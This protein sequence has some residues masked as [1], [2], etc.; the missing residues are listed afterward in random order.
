MKNPALAHFDEPGPKTRR[1][2]TWLTIAGAFAL[3]GIIYYVLHRFS[4]T[5]QLDPSKWEPFLY[6]DI[7]RELLLGLWSTLK[8]ALISSVLTLLI[9]FSFGII[10]LSNSPWIRLPITYLIELIRGVPVLLMIFIMFYLGSG[11]LSP[12]WSVVLGVSIFNGSVVA[13]IVRAGI[14]SLPKG[15]TEAGSAIGLRNF[16]VMRY[17]RLPQAIRAMMPALVGQMVVMLKDSS[18][19]YLVTYTDLLYVTNNLGRDFNNLL[20]TFLVGAAVYVLLNICLGGVAKVLELRMSGGFGPLKSKTT[21]QFLT[22]G[23]SGRG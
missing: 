20:P 1:L 6:A 12:Y 14:L 2:I 15:Q 18:L 8:V 5:G 7:Q 10:Q 4:V 13:E 19:G 9:G 21:T 23:V 16:Q 11:T 3:L 17:I 22:R